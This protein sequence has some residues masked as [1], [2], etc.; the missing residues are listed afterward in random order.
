MTDLNQLRAESDQLRGA[1]DALAR[2]AINDL[3]ACPSPAVRA[4]VTLV[5]GEGQDNDLWTAIAEEA[6]RI[7]WAGKT[8]LHGWMLKRLQQGMKEGPNGKTH[9]C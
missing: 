6:V 5:L 9:P 3:M 2:A 8:E 7:T 1:A 4:R